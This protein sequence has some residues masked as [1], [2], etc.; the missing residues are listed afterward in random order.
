VEQWLEHCAA[1]LQVRIQFIL[2]FMGCVSLGCHP[3]NP[4]VASTEASSPLGLFSIC[5]KHTKM[6][7]TAFTTIQVTMKIIPVLTLA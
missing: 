2:V 5:N 1:N 7:H 6:Q 4:C 3:Y